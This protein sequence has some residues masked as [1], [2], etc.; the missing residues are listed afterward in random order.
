MIFETV[1]FKFLDLMLEMTYSFGG[2]IDTRRGCAPERGRLSDVLAMKNTYI[3]LFYR[4]PPKSVD[5]A[6]KKLVFKGIELLSYVGQSRTQKNSSTFMIPV[7][8]TLF[9]YKFEG[10]S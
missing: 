9:L 3:T 7:S 4:S 2:S 6:R 8:G 1:G 10:R 5:G